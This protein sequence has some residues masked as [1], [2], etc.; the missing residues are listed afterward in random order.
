M[1]HVQCRVFLAVALCLCLPAGLPAAADTVELKNG[2]VLKGTI[3]EQNDDVVV[4]EHDSL[5]RIAVPRDQVAELAV[6]EPP[7][8]GRPLDEPAEAVEPE[9]E[10]KE[11]DHWD[12][13]LDLSFTATTGNTEEVNLRFGVNAKRETDATR[14]GID[15]SYYWRTSDSVTTDNKATLGARND[16]LIPASKWFWFVAG[17]AD[18]DQFQS[19]DYRVNAQGGPGYQFIDKEDLTW[20]GSGGLG[21]RKEWGSIDDG[22]KFEGVLETN[23]LWNPT[24]RQEISFNFSYFPV[25]TDIRD[26]RFRSTALWRY[27]LDADYTLALII[28]YLWEYQSIVDPG[29]KRSDFRFWVGLQYGF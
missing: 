3:V 6:G 11:I 24:E 2:D 9:P 22:L 18:Y 23:L 28:G 25:M 19:W 26:Y 29:S 7:A 21:F 4:I 10:K 5:G 27:A 12:L 1:V 20:S 14:L 8:D 17:R 16:W 15:F 13:T